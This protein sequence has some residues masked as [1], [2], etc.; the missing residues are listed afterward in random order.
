[1]AETG[2][3]GD[4]VLSFG[5]YCGKKLHQV[6]WEYVR[7]L[8]GYMNNGRSVVTEWLKDSAESLMDVI[9]DEEAAKRHVLENYGIKDF[10]WKRG[11]THAEVRTMLYNG[12]NTGVIKKV[13]WDTYGIMAW[14]YVYNHQTEAIGKACDYLL[15]ERRICCYCGERLV[16]IGS[17][18]ANGRGH[19]DWHGR[20]LHKTCYR[21]VMFCET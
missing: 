6:P 17:A 10:P 3:S 5:K 19:D 8:S 9:D 7:W 21:R 16:P 18:R 4:Y 14:K 1:M 15:R 11:M 2:N 20:K 12:W 13:H